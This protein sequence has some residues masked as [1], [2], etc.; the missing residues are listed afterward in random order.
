MNARRALAELMKTS[1]EYRDFFRRCCEAGNV[2]L[3]AQAWQFLHE[4]RATPMSVQHPAGVWSS[5]SHRIR[6]RT[7]AS[8]AGAGVQPRG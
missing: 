4:L 2:R 8:R 1:P 5:V 6:R 3:R 7:I